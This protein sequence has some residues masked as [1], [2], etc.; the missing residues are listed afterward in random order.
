MPLP[1]QVPFL[2]TD[3]VQF[4][5]SRTCGVA[6][7]H[8]FKG[9]SAPSKE[10]RR[11]CPA[12]GYTLKAFAAMCLFPRLIAPGLLLSSSLVAA[13]AFVLFS[14]LEQTTARL[15]YIRAAQHRVRSQQPHLHL[16]TREATKG[17]PNDRAKERGEKKGGELREGR[18]EGGGGE[19]GGEGGG[20]PKNCVVGGE[21]PRLLASVHRAGLSVKKHVCLSMG[22]VDSLSRMRAGHPQN[23]WVGPLALVNM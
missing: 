11:K 10:E 14:F 17:A 7:L 20:A 2:D 16:R 9:V 4:A 18:G 23:A 21:G 5:C 13:L 19:G 3:S 22:N 12:G 6:L 8:S 15:V 1:P